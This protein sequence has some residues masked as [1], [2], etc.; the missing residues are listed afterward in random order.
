MIC[1]FKP[2]GVV[3]LQRTSGT[4]SYSLCTRLLIQN[5]H[6]YRSRIPRAQHPCGLFHTHLRFVV[7]G[8]NFLGRHFYFHIPWRL[9]HQSPRAW[10]TRH[11]W[12]W[13]TTVCNNYGSY[14]G[15]DHRSR[16]PASLFC[17]TVSWKYIPTKNDGEDQ[18]LEKYPCLLYN[19]GFWLS[20][21]LISVVL[22]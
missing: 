4:L 20:W 2:V 15:E 9:Y 6:S 14:R 8:A 12:M 17:Q 18:K 3:L 19:S 11:R 1:F 22:K 7:H 10:S 13:N 16:R 21:S 5:Q